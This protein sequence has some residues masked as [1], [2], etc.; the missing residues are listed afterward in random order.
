MENTREK[1]DPAALCIRNNSIPKPNHQ[2]IKN[3]N[4]DDG[5][6]GLAVHT[7]PVGYTID[8]TNDIASQPM[9]N[10]QICYREYNGIKRYTTDPAM[11]G[12]L[13]NHNLAPLRLDN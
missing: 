10:F 9:G 11:V 12:L 13:R 4:E 6:T 3:K 1:L 8:Y 7:L 2:K 5:S